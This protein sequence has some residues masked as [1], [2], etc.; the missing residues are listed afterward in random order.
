[1]N[2]KI[3]W[4]G[5]LT[6]IITVFSCML[7]L[8][9]TSCIP[10]LAVAEQVRSSAEYFEDRALFPYLLDGQFNCRQDNY[11]DAILINIL[12][13]IGQAPDESL[14][15]SVMRGAYYNEERQN[16][17]EALAIAVEAPQ[18]ANVDYFRY[19]HGSLVL[20]R[21]LFVLTDVTGVRLI[22][23]IMAILSYLAASILLWKKGERAIAICLF[24]GFLLVNGWM[25]MLCIEYVTMLLLS[26]VISLL[27]VLSNH[28]ETEIWNR[29]K[30][31]LILMVL[32]G[33]LTCFLDFLTTETLTF[34]IPMFLEL[35]LERHVSWKNQEVQN[36]VKSGKQKPIG[37]FGRDLRW[38]LT[39]G[40]VWGFSYAGMFLIKWGLSAVLFGKEAFLAALSSASERVS[41]TVHLGDTS[42]DPE[43]SGLQ[44]L[45][46]ALSR[47]ISA[48]F[49]FRDEMNTAVG[50]LLFFLVL[51]VCFACIYVLHT[52]EFSFGKIGIFL[53][54]AALPYVR[55]LALSNH[56]YMHYF[57][58]YRAQMITILVC[59]YLTWEYGVKH[60]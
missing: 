39:C 47:N 41:G 24:A 53:V 46:G 40:I 35:V 21:P 45:S 32:S 13:H 8:V 37:Q 14:F 26:G 25:G 31:V 33:V 51:F 6:F 27:I 58:T 34:T 42:L 50:V 11:A 36:N 44:R 22:L 56:S 1:M 48:L 17:N 57:F 30:R 18:H 29:H 10:Q 9:G 12:Y 52:K 3:V 15:S 49:P 20:L 23:G 55:Y 60:L 5:I 7:L 2:K 54:L 59:L 16:V 38:T 4:K 19:W 43:A 28:H